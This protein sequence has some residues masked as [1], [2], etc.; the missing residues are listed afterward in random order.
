MVLYAK[1]YGVVPGKDVSKEINDMFASLSVQTEP[2]I[3]ILE[4]GIY[5][6]TAD[7]C[8]KVIMYISNASVGDS[9]MYGNQEGDD[10]HVVPVGWDLEN[11]QNVTVQG[12]GARFVAHGKMTHIFLRHCQHLSVDGVTFS[13]ER[14]DFHFVQ[15]QRV[16]ETYVDF[17]L[18]ASDDYQKMNE[19]YYFCLLY[20][21]PSP[22]D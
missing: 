21:S 8:P 6:L 16:S 4:P 15:V 18:D 1:H 3:V 5:H 14:P 12:K 17:A 10:L 13:A 9:S 2:V 7:H 11:L 22:R 20:T 19:M